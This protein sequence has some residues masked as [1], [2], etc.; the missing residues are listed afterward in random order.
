MNVNMVW[1]HDIE[2]QT[3]KDSFN[4]DTK[5]DFFLSRFE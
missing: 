3:T 4:D 5:E 1:V 2:I